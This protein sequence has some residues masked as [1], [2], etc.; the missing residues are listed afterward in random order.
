[1]ADLAWEQSHYVRTTYDIDT[2]ASSMG[3]QYANKAGDL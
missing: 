1:M 3:H 2:D